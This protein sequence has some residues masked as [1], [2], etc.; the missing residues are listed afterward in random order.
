MAS[1]IPPASV[2]S[3]S[4]SMDGGRI[5]GPDV[6][7]LVPDTIRFRRNRPNQ[8]GGVVLVGADNVYG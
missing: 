1:E 5:A 4:A 6:E 3:D 2:Q 8:I 7:L